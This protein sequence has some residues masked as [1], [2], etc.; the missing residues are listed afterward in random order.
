MA[1]FA[2]QVNVPP[3]LGCNVVL[4]LVG[5]ARSARFSEFLQSRDHAA[6]KMTD[7][8]FSNV[9]NNDRDDSGIS[10]WFDLEF[11]GV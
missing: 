5:G 9:I 4:L 6:R 1:P 7:L 3:H 2:N 11:Q 8:P 10:K